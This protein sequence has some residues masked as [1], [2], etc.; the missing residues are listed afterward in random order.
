MLIRTGAPVLTLGLF[1]CLYVSSFVMADE[2]ASVS[3]RA[4]S[5]WVEDEHSALYWQGGASWR[6]GKQFYIDINVNRLSSDLPFADLTN[7]ALVYDGGFDTGYAGLHMRGG[8]SRHGLIDMNIAD[9]PFYNKGGEGFFVNPS[10]PVRLGAFTLTPSFLY[11]AAEWEDGS[12]YWFYGKPDIPALRVFGLDVS[13][14]GRQRL[15]AK[16]FSLDL[17]ILNNEETLLFESRFTGFFASYTE[18]RRYSQTWLEAGLGWLYAAGSLQGALTAENQQY[19]LFPFAF[20]HV[21][22]SVR[23]HI[24]HASLSILYKPSVFRYSLALGALYIF[25]GHLDVTGHYR[26]K[27]IFGGGEFLENIDAGDFSHIGL[28]YML[29]DAGIRPKIGQSK[30]ARFSLGLQKAF[31]LPWGYE[32]YM[33]DKESGGGGASSSGSG[34]Q[35]KWLK[36]ALLSGLSFYIKLSL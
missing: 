36:T 17:D 8:F 29:V 32:K 7:R 12:F 19:W 27:N 14:E 5:L 30:M 13:H 18:S 11:G 9:K 15:S 33:A 34:F 28:A 25:R 31:L 6:Q 3:G 1:L 10:L 24:G 23:T 35:M 4:G 2:S 22:A 26:R 16:Y 20:F 21:D